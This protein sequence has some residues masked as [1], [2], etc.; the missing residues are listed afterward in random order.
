MPASVSGLFV[1]KANGIGAETLDLQAN[2]SAPCDYSASGL[3]DLYSEPCRYQ[4]LQRAH[5]LA[6]GLREKR[7]DR[8]STEQPS[9]SDPGQEGGAALSSGIFWVAG[10]RDRATARFA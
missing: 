6:L 10:I 8:G 5:S 7:I 9:V 4:P 1:W 3:G 2:V